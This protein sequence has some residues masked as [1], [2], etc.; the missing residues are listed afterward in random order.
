MS[1]LGLSTSLYCNIYN[2]LDARNELSVWNDT[3]RS[4]YT[5][6][7]RDVETTDPGRIGHLNEHLLRPE[8]YGEPRRINIG[9]KVGL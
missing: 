5:L 7:A 6:T 3:G 9:L 4:T 2:I 1:L 8:W